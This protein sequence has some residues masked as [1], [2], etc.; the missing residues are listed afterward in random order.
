MVKHHV[1]F[2]QSQNGVKV[3]VTKTWDED[4]AYVGSYVEASC[5]C[6]G[7]LL[8]THSSIDCP[9]LKARKKNH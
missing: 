9:V 3:I 7:S 6:F 8:R 1:K 4:G 5:N 2:D